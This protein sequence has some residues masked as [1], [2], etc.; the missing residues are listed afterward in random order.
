MGC[1]K[2]APLPPPETIE[3][4]KG[5]ST[6]MYGKTRQPDYSAE[7]AQEDNQQQEGTPHGATATPAACMCSAHHGD[8]GM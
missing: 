3:V 6:I 2:S 8:H 5:G 4:G 7:K 1:S